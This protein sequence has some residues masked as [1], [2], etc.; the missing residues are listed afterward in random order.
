[1]RKTERTRWTRDSRELLV[2]LHN[3]GLRPKKIAA[4]LGRTPRAIVAQINH[5]R[6]Y[7]EL[8]DGRGIRRL[9]KGWTTHQVRE[10]QRL[11]LQGW[12]AKQIALATDRSTAAIRS[13][14]LR[15]CSDLNAK[16]LPCLKSTT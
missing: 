9:Y 5:L 6:T 2:D 3:A 8:V 15:F 1:M 7:P 13:A 16:E 12:T 4:A 10:L 11:V 14:R